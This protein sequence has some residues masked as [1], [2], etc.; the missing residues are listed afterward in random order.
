LYAAFPVTLMSPTVML[1]HPIRWLEA[2][3]RYHAT[4]SGGPNFAYDLCLR[5]ITPAQ[6]ATLDLRSWRVAFNGA[7]PIRCETLEH[8]ATFFAPCGFRREAFYPCYGLAEATLMV[9]GGLRAVRPVITAVRPAALA[10]NRVCPVMEPEGERRSLVGCGQNL[11][12]QRL[13]LVD[14]QTLTPCAPTQ[15]GEIWVAGPSIAQGYWNRPE[16]T[17]DIFSAYLADT[18][19]GPYLRTGDVGF[20]Q[21]GELFITGRHKDLVIIAGRNHYPQDIEWTVER[22]HPAIRPSGCAAF[23]IDVAGQEQVVVVAEIQRSF[24]TAILADD[25]VPPTTSACGVPRP[26]SDVVQ[27]IR[28]AMARQHDLQVYAV[29][30]LKAGSLPKTSSGKMQRHACC[31]RFVDGTLDPLVAWTMG[32]PAPRSRIDEDSASA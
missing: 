29:S 2:I 10:Q 19:E 5:R 1:Q 31:T 32:L 9:S 17:A 23:S 18:G 25:A 20:L 13:L 16:E 11:A 24:Q 22:S 4:T 30:L 27:A 15:V 28:Q 21:D 12:E 26:A 6:R 3:T 8:F 7:E 14:P